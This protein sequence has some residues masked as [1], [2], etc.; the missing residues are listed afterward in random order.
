MADHITYTQ[1]DTRWH[2]VPNG[3]SWMANACCDCGLVHG[4]QFRIHRR[5]IYKRTWRDERRT[6]L[7]RRHMVRRLDIVRV[8]R[9][10]LYILPLRIQRKKKPAVNTTIKIKRV[11]K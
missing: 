8:P 2:P 11:K 4:V 7:I 3:K 6:A 10:N 1:G 5:K 9:S